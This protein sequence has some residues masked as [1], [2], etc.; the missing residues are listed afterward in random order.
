MTARILPPIDHRRH[1]A[2][3]RHDHV[4]DFVAA[5]VVEDRL[6][7][8]RVGAVDRHDADRR[9]AVGSKGSTTGGRVP[10]GRLGITA[11]ATAS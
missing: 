7:V 6:V 2:R 3:D 10:G 8:R 11:R 4:A 1:G 9:R 5:H